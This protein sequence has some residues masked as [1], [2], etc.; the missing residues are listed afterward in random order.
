MEIYMDGHL[1]RLLD[2]LAQRAKTGEVF[3]FKELI[4]FYMLDVL[5]ELA[6]SQSFDA[7]IEQVPEKLPPINDHVFLACLMGMTPEVLPYLRSVAAWTPLPWLQRL[8]KARAQLKA[9]TAQCVRRRLNEKVSGRKDLL[10]SLI[11]AID[12]E[13]GARLTEVDINTE[14]FAMV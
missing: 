3:D 1:K 14:A 12:P 5:G 9:L 2:N 13:T 8:F 11:N 4:A 10:S 7:Q 6:F